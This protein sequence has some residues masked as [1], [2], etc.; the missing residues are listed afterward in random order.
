MAKLKTGPEPPPEIELAAER[1]NALLWACNHIQRV[2]NKPFDL[3][4]HPYLWD[5][6]D[7]PAQE[8]VTRKSSQTR[9]SMT[10]IHRFIHK[11]AM[12][13]WNG[14]YWF[15]TD[16][17]LYPFMQSRFD[18]LVELN[19]DLS[20]LL[21]S[22][23]N[24]KTKLIG[25]AFAYF[26]GLESKT[27]KESTPAD[28]M[29]F[30]E[31]D[32][33][34]P[35]DVEIA[36]ERMQDSP[37]KYV[38]II[39]NPTLPDFGV[40]ALL[41]DS[42][43]QCWTM[44]CK[45]GHWNECDL[46]TEETPGDAK[47]IFPECIEQ[48]FL[49][50]SKCY[51]P[52]D[53]LGGRWI[54]K[55]PKIKRSGRFVSRLFVHGTDMVGLLEE[56]RKAF[57]KANFYNRRLGL[58]Y[59][60]THSRITKEQVLKL[61]GS[62]NMQEHAFKTTMGIDVNPEAGHH[63]VVS[64]PGRTRLRDII[65][66][67]VVKDLDELPLIIR[68]LDVKKFVIDA[69]P[70]LEHARKLCQKFPG[71]G[72]MCYYNRHQK[73]SYAWDDDNHKVSVNRTESLDASQRLLREGLIELPL[74]NS[75]VDDFAEHCGNIAKRTTFDETTGEPSVEYVQLGVNKPDHFRHAFNYDGICWYHGQGGK[76]LAQ[77]VI[78]NNVRD[79]VED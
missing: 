14:I 65:A 71:K 16:T 57:S 36:R 43:F 58:P 35:T 19:R 52:L 54:A 28:H 27:N 21:R 56:Y 77:T 40:D 67:G 59:A 66:I 24:V 64:R 2:D 73:D 46:G 39:G 26:F 69:Q 63:Y 50:C 42:S 1:F 20:D 37:H 7:D 12:R 49:A 8:T 74:R 48:G 23:D 17:A 41:K 25:Q 44:K 79:I 76:P 4:R 30:D 32:L 22:T 72:F 5:V 6:Y 9:F 51:R 18:R 3:S 34:L 29:V 70:D 55:Y 62:Q 10:M 61:C 75:V 38:D 11:T 68:K 60:D 78:P 33:M 13:G 45:S 53:V 47:M 31:Y 15:P